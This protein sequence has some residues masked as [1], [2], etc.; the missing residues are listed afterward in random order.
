MA[1]VRQVLRSKLLEITPG[2]DLLH[3]ERSE[4]D[5]LSVLV[6]RDVLELLNQVVLLQGFSLE[7]VPAQQRQ[8]TQL[9]EVELL[10]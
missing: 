8:A 10:D 3:H 7:G 9:A 6:K 2:L 4:H 1:V 5:F